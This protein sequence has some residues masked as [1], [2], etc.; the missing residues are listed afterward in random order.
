MPQDPHLEPL[1]IAQDCVLSRDQ[2]LQAGISRRGIEHRLA[3]RAWRR[4]LPSVYLVGR[5]EPTRTQAQIAALLYAGEG[6]ALDD[7]DAC[8][9]AGLTAVSYVKGRV[10]VAVPEQSSARSYDFVCVR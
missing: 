5:G 3:T 9:C 8:Q 6:S 10:F 4:L 2:A 1:L 7:A